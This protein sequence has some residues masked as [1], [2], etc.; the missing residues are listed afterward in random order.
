M[1]DDDMMAAAA[2]DD[3]DLELETMSTIS[4]AMKRVTGSTRDRVTDWFVSKYA[5]GRH[6]APA[7]PREAPAAAAAPTETSNSKSR[8]TKKRRAKTSGTSATAPA[9]KPKAAPGF[10]KTLNLHPS[11]KTSFK[12]FV[13]EKKPADN[14]YEHNVVAAY[15]LANVAEVDNVTADQ[16]FTCYRGVGWK[17]PGDLRNNLAKTAHEK[18]WLDT[19]DSDN[20]TVAPQ[21]LNFVDLELPRPE[22]KK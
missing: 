4:T 18:G 21:G 13:A 2:A 14:G 8:S 10:D 19:K 1:T 16:I 7:A 12:D 5:A 20:I 17:L 6:S 22:K 9:N 11:G 3:D 15:W